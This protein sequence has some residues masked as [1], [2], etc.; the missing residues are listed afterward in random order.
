MLG[1]LSVFKEPSHF[2]DISPDVRIAK[3]IL[4]RV[5]RRGATDRQKPVT[6]CT[7][8]V[9]VFCASGEIQGD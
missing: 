6:L 1:E 7:I 3:A 9:N 4:P 5:W 8:S 2:H